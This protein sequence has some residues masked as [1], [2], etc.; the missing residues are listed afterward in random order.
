MKYKCNDMS[1]EKQTFNN[2]QSHA[3]LADV[4]V[5]YFETLSVLTAKE[6]IKN[7]ALYA[8]LIVEIPTKMKHLIDKKRWERYCVINAR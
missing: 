6:E 3:P 8:G 4:N 1:N 7:G 5:R 2:E